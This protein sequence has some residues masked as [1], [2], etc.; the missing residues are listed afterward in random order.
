MYLNIL[1]K[2]ALNVEL[3][4]YDLNDIRINKIKIVK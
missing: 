2:N 4:K 1:D 3:V